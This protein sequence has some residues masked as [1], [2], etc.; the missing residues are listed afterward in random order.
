VGLGLGLSVSPLLTQPLVHVPAARAADVSGLLATTVQ[1]GQLMGVAVIG[2]VYLSRSALSHAAGPRLGR[3]P[4]RPAGWPPC[5]PLACC[6]RR[7]W[8]GPPASLA[9]A[10]LLRPDVM[11]ECIGAAELAG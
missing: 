8:S 2:S 7:S 10:G 3:C 11:L 4:A 5:S 1:F 9:A 6:R